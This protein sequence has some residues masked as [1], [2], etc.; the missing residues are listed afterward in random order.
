MK[1]IAIFSPKGGVG[2][3]TFTIL[4]ASYLQYSTKKSVM[5]LDCD[6]PQHSIS[7]IRQREIAVLKEDIDLKS[8]ISQYHK[9]NNLD[10]Y[11]I[12][13]LDIRELKHNSIDNTEADYLIY[14]L[15]G[16][17]N[18]PGVIQTLIS[19]DILIIP[20]EV[21]YNVFVPSLEFVQALDIDKSKVFFLFNKIDLRENQSLYQSLN[22]Y[23]TKH[24]YN[25][26]N[27]IL[28]YSTQ[29][30]KE[31]KSSTNPVRSTL[32]APSYPNTKMGEA[33]RAL[34]DEIIKNI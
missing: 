29:I 5:V 13:T 28:P 26:L 3:S 16:T 31:L 11:P 27:T 17:L 23:L 21:D 15:P 14:D 9:E 12:Q 8:N 2:K 24:E 1:K 25:V 18:I 30:K 32:R 20:V 6:M 7:K 4:L 34:L 19:L 10:I 22:E 33:L